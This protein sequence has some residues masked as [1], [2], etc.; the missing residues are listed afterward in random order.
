MNSVSKGKCEIE[1]ILS[2]DFFVVDGKKTAVTHL[3]WRKAMEYVS[4]TTV[5]YNR[6]RFVHVA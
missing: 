4:P 1:K 5:L 6:A 3:H 2:I